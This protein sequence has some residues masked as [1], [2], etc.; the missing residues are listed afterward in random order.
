MGKTIWCVQI[1]GFICPGHLECSD[2]S[3]CPWLTL[4]LIA[5][6]IAAIKIAKE[7]TGT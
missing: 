1:P 6:M 4:D 5:E 7:E 2:G 3:P